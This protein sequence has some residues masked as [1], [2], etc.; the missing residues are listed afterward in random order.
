MSG[1][2]GTLGLLQYSLNF[3]LL[4]YAYSINTKLL[5]EIQLICFINQYLSNMLKYLRDIDL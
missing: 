4:D 2:D 5:A 3:V 1:S